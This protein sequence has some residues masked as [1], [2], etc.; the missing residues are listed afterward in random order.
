MP[1]DESINSLSPD[2]NL[3]HSDAV[4]RSFVYPYQA[5]VKLQPLELYFLRPASGKDLI[6][7]TRALL[8]LQPLELYTVEPW[9]VRHASQ[10]MEFYAG[11]RYN[12]L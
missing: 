1:V 12:S 11:V 3:T 7:S 10:R 6:V 5:D 8:S 2:D 4:S 9:L